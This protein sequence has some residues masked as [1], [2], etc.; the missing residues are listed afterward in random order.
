[1]KNVIVYGVI[2]LLAFA[3][4]TGAL[5]FLNSKYKNIF[6]FDFSPETRQGKKENNKLAV[7][8]SLKADSK[9]VQDSVAIAKDSTAISQDSTKK[10]QNEKKNE[11]SES[12]LNT[13][14]LAEKQEIT[15]NPMLPKTNNRNT[16]KKDSVYQ[17]WLKETVK[18]YEAMDSKIV[19]KVILGYSDNIARD[20]ILR[21]R[22]KK[23]AEVLSEFKPE[24]VTR[25]INVN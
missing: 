1:V 6:A 5:V 23:A 18:L 4:V 22:K 12:K 20:L 10:V 8:D 21:M 11:F 13:N 2:F 19:A 14:K 7:A 16:A 17:A 24:V 25:L 15:D 9:V 3:M